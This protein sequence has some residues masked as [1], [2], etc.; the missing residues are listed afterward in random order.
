RLAAV[1]FAPKPTL[2][3]QRLLRV[4]DTSTGKEILTVRDYQAQA[5][6]LNRDG[7]RLAAHGWNNRGG[8]QFVVWKVPS[9]KQVCEIQPRQYYASGVLLLPSHD[10]KRL[11]TAAYGK[12]ETWDAAT[13]KPVAVLKNLDYQAPTRI[14]WSPDDQYLLIS[15]SNSRSVTV[16]NP[17]TGAAGVTIG[18]DKGEE[19]ISAVRWSPDSKH[20]AGA[21]GKQVLKDG[22][23][24]RI[25]I[26]KVWDPVTGKSRELP[27]NHTDFISD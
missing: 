13:G 7:T 2:R 12:V 15:A 27:G 20:L 23:S 10:G 1:A 22:S 6:T 24:R 11:A 25:Y 3:S 21:V 4:W 8:G 18:V 14:A 9:G 17:K 26:A 5:I 19:S 16:S